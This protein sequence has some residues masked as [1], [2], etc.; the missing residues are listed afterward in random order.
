[1][2]PLHWSS[3]D[4][5]GPSRKIRRRCSEESARVN[6]MFSWRPVSDISA[7]IPIIDLGVAEIDKERR[8]ALAAP[9]FLNLWRDGLPI[10]QFRAFC[11]NEPPLDWQMVERA[12]ETLTAVPS[13]QTSRSSISLVI[14]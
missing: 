10:A 14:C 1:M 6:A 4:S 7:P 5:K 11:S 3:C 13:P 9:Y 2:I 12:C 8:K